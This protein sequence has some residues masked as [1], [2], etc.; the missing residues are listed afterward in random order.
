M[1]QTDP[2]RGMSDESQVLPEH[3]DSQDRSQRPGSR[4][5]CGRRIAATP[6]Y[7]RSRH[8]RKKVEMLFAHLKRIL[9]LDRLRLRGMGGATDE[10]TLAAAVQNPRRLAKFSSQGPPVTG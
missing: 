8:E 6:A 7:Q 5:R 4:S 9:K 3:F 1:I 10:F 2:L